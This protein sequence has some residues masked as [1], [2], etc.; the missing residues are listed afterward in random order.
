MKTIWV[1]GA[2]I[3]RD[4]EVLAALRG[5]SMSHPGVWEFPGGKV[6]EGE[7]P[8]E[9]LARELEEELGVEADV[10]ELIARGESTVDGRR[11]ILDVFACRIRAGQPVAREHAELRWVSRTAIDDVEWAEADLP[12]VDALRR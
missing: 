8:R 5:P 4:D 7:T 2:A 11:I 12:A 6:E 9:C 1:V 10:G 3:L